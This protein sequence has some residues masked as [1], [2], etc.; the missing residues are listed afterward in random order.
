MDAAE[1]YRRQLLE[2]SQYIYY[3]TPIS[4]ATASAYLATPRHLFVTSYREWGSKQWH[5][6]HEEN[7][8]EHV[9]ALYA[10]RPL[11][12]FGEDDDNIPSTI[13]QPSFV[14]RMLDLLRLSPGHKVF[15]LGAGSGWNAALMARLVGPEGHVYSLEI[16]SEVAKA[17]AATIE[18]MGI[19]NVDI[20]VAD[21]GEGY[22]A[23]APYDRAIFTAGTYDLPRPKSDPISLDISPANG[24]MSGNQGGWDEG[25]APEGQTR[26]Q[27]TDARSDRGRPAG[28]LER[29]AEDGVGVAVTAR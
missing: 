5:R 10:N 7:L 8:Q 3:D 4:E 14:L 24:G 23:A 28:A 21:G 11:I 25:Q 2:Q 17:A 1:K 6:V 15:E 27:R 18:T 16:I 9:A 22:V 12:L 26:R 20:I 29:T 13:S 19:R